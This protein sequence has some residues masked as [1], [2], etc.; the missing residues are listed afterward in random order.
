MMQNKKSMIEVVEKYFSSVDNGNTGLLLDQLTP[1]CEISVVTE[2]VTFKGRDTE[3]KEMFDRRLENTDKAW[4]GNFKHLADDER[5]WVTSRFDVR[6]TS[7]DG[8][9]RE[10]D[11]INFFEFD[12]VLIKRISIWMSG[13]SSLK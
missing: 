12:S 7:N 8:I 9:Y 1:D 10:M 6:R 3:I 13:E 4:H 2:P 11:N 5:G